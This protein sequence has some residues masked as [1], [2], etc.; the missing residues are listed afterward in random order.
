MNDK[1]YG[2]DLGTT[3]SAV[4]VIND[5]GLPE[6]VKNFIN[7]DTTPSVV[8]FEPDGNAVI[9]AQAK[10]AQVSEPDNACSLIK[11][12]MGEQYPLEFQGQSYSPES[13]SAIIL[14]ELVGA[15]NRQNG[16]GVNKVVIT[17]PAYFGIQERAATRQAGEIAGLD[18][19]GI[20]PEPVAAAISLG[21]RQD[22]EQTLLIFDLGG[23][24]FDTTILKART[25]HVDVV[26]IDGNRL[27]GGA[28][29]DRRLEDLFLEKFVAQAGLD[30][31]PSMDDEFFTDLRVQVEG[32]KKTLTQR[33]ST[34]LL[35]RYE[36]KR[37]N[38][39]VTRNDFEAAT[40][41]LVAQTVEI[42]RRVISTA[43]AK[44]PG[45]SVDRV[46]LVGGSARMPM[47]E[48]ALKE[49]GLNPEPTDYDLSVAKG[50]AVFGQG[51]LIEIDEK[52]GSSAAGTE[53]ADEEAAALPGIRPAKTVVS[54]VL[55]RGL[56]ILL[57]REVPG[58]D[59]EDYVMFLAHAQEKL[60]L[61]AS[62]QG[63]IL[64]DGQQSVEVGL[65]EQSGDVESEDPLANKPMVTGP[66][67][68]ISGLPP[69]KKGDPID[70]TMRVSEEGIAMLVVVEPVS[71]LSFEASA[72]VSVL[73]TEEVAAF[74]K[75]V[76]R[77]TTSS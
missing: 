34:K 55:S 42:T 32:A 64:R 59:Y 58:G 15:A 30:D 45:L 52:R 2:I 54:H 38:V 70:V 61:T 7:E 48:S 18:V 3:Y 22:E 14:K 50:A 75:Q 35:L 51:E 5:V 43:Q 33:A 56:G 6:M 28:D 25:G 68:T 4:A 46:L 9:G 67:T 16:L 12:H 23:G 26:A 13:I 69:M 74:T 77:I 66:N 71:G 62:M 10:Q 1:V 11:R 21:T 73:T 60:P 47:I 57:A 65:Y 49:A 24:T 37:E 17:V 44:E 76:A 40:A 27:L 8:L 72:A 29:W 39:E 63:G 20:I 31:D 19:V 41:D 36:D 53:G